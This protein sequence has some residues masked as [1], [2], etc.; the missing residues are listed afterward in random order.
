MG[1]GYRDVVLADHINPVGHIYLKLRRKLVPFKR[2]SD[3]IFMLS[4]AAADWL[5]PTVT[6]LPQGN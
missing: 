3:S 2:M 4:L 5:F 6:A 1:S